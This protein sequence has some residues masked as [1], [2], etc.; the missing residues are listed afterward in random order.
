MDRDAFTHVPEKVGGR[1]GVDG[2]QAVDAV[3]P[4]TDPHLRRALRDLRGGPSPAPQR[5]E[6]AR[7]ALRA[8]E[9]GARSALGELRLLLHAFRP[10]AGEDR[11]GE[12]QEPGPSLSAWT[13]WP[14]PC[15]RPG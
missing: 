8:I 10:D 14:T 3:G 11:V 9:S 12:Q 6:Q 5:L 2:E 4:T 13:S 7:Q 1:H 15:A